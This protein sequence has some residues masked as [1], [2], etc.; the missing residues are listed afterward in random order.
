MFC[1]CDTDFLTVFT[2]L[3]A[4]SMNSFISLWSLP[5]VFLY[6][7]SFLDIRSVGRW[8][9]VNCLFTSWD[10]FCSSVFHSDVHSPNGRSVVITQRSLRKIVHQFGLVKDGWPF[11]IITSIVGF[12]LRSLVRSH[13]K[14]APFCC[15][16]KIY[17][18]F[19]S[20][21]A[22]NDF[23]GATLAGLYHDICKIYVRITRSFTLSFRRPPE[24][25]AFPSGHGHF[26]HLPKK[27]NLLAVCAHIKI[28]DSPISTPGSDTTKNIWG[29]QVRPS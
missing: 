22:P 5:Y 26:T 18:S 28:T 9:D 7:W 1:R 17:S 6:W 4:D 23:H 20:Y 10:L 15:A 8:R 11:I 29:L 3:W 12:S 27:G 24:A 14:H 25:H 16:H 2:G 21:I 13:T 19:I